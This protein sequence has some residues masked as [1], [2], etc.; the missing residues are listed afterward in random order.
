M[1]IYA[2]KLA[3][4]STNNKG[5][6]QARQETLGQI[7]KRR[8]DDKQRFDTQMDFV[9][10]IAGA[11]L[12]GL[13]ANNRN[14]SW[15]YPLLILGLLACYWSSRNIL[16]TPR[17]EKC[18]L[19]TSNS[20]SAHSIVGVFPMT[21]TAAQE[22]LRPDKAYLRSYVDSLS[23]ELNFCLSKNKKIVSHAADMWKVPKEERLVPNT[24]QEEHKQQNSNNKKSNQA[25]KVFFVVSE[26]PKEKVFRSGIPASSPLALY[27]NFFDVVDEFVTQATA[28]QRLRHR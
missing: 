13:A 11:F 9:K 28:T 22:I 21:P 7:S 26:L 1:F 12:L 25:H 3:E 10:L 15:C 5:M 23:Y 14:N 17:S 19:N 2:V 16:Q 20:L 8:I 6:F 4:S 18:V 24:F 27:D